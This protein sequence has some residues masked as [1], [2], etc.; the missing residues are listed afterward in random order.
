MHSPLLQAEPPHHSLNIHIYFLSLWLQLFSSSDLWNQ[1][2]PSRYLVTWSAMSPGLDL[3]SSRRHVPGCVCDGVSRKMSWG[4]KVTTSGHSAGCGSTLNLKGGEEEENVLNG[5]V[6]LWFLSAHSWTL[7]SGFTLPQPHLFRHDELWAE[8]KPAFLQ[9]LLIKCLVTAREKYNTFL[10][11]I[12]FISSPSQ[13]YSPL[14]GC[15]IR[16][17]AVPPCFTAATCMFTSV[18]VVAPN[19][20]TRPFFHH[21]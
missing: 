3:E 17:W 18:T 7:R 14:W 21:L 1:L 20:R 4:G 16:S 15:L 12:F 10:M 19:S 11:P 5:S 2:K 13:N 9:S 6:H 8:R